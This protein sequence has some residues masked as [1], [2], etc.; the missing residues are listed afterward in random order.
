MDRHLPLLPSVASVN[1]ITLAWGESKSAATSVLF[2]LTLSQKIIGQSHQV[3]KRNLRP[4]P[5]TISADEE[6]GCHYVQ[7]QK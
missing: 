1:L 4:F 5:K 3:H 7:E 6:E 2:P